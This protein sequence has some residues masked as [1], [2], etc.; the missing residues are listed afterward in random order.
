MH[1][2]VTGPFPEPIHRGTR[3]ATK[4]D[5]ICHNSH[6][7]GIKGEHHQKPIRGN[8]CRRH[9]LALLSGVAWQ[10]TMLVTGHP[11][12]PAVYVTDTAKFLFPRSQSGSQQRPAMR[13]SSSRV[14]RDRWRRRD[15]GSRAERH[16]G[17][18]RYCTVCLLGKAV[19]SQLP[20]YA[21]LARRIQAKPRR[22]WALSI[23]RCR[24]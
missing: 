21:P 6:L 4:K 1:E 15:T 13:L 14:A 5:S 7:G 17:Y 20:Y 3:Y 16:S 19:P 8:G 10:T 22:P 11:N 9:H 2:T 24:N 12:G 18:W 23:T